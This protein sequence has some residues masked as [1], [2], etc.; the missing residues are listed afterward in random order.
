MAM[1]LLPPLQRTLLHHDLSFELRP[2]DLG[3]IDEIQ[4]IDQESFPTP[5]SRA[6]LLGEFTEEYSLI[7]GLLRSNELCGY[8]IA[9]LVACELHVLSLAV[10]P[11]YRKQGLAAILLRE[12]LEYA[13]E[14]GATHAFLEVRAGN[15]AAQRLYRSFGFRI[16]HVR[17]SYYEDRNEDAIVFEKDIRAEQ[18]E[19][20]ANARAV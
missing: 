9:H 13:Y 5:W 11:Q 15:L 19:K 7:L 10:A 20:P 18:S 8:L 16:S 2:L 4:A 17:K 1:A 6:M 3:F 12:T 14:Q